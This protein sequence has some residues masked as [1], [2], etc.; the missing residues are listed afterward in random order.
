[1]QQR[2]AQ[3]DVAVVG[4]GPVGAAAAVAF[5]RRGARVLLAEANPRAASRFAGEWIHPPGVDVLRRLDLVPVEG[6]SAHASGRGFVVLPDDGGEP[7]LLPYADG[8]AGLSCEHA[9]LVQ[10]LR[11]RAAALPGV[12]YRPY[13]RVTEVDPG[14]LTIAPRGGAPETVRAGLVVGADGRSSIVRQR[15][16]APPEA[17]LMSHMAGL[18]LHGARLPFEGHGHVLLGGPGP[19]LLYRIGPDTLRICL[20]LPVGTPGARRDAAYLWEAFG[21]VLPGDVRAAFR[22]ALT[23]GKPQW[24]TIRFRARNWYGRDDVTVIGDAVGFYHPLTAAGITLGLLDAECLAQ[25]GSV[26]AYAAQREQRSY[27]PELLS[28]ALYEVLTREDRSA[29][30]I[31]S[32]V[33]D[34]WRTSARERACTMRILST[35]DTDRATFGA[36]FVRMA[37]EAV[38]RTRAEA[39]GDGLRALASDLGSFGEWVQWPAASLLPRRLR[40]RCRSASTAYGPMHAIGVVPARQVVQDDLER[41][42]RTPDE[43]RRAR[44]VEAAH[45][46]LARPIDWSAVRRA[47]DRADALGTHARLRLALRDVGGATGRAVLEPRALTAME[48]LVG[49]AATPALAAVARAAIAGPDRADAAALR[50]LV[51][52]LVSRQDADGGFDGGCPVATSE[53]AIALAEVGAAYPGLDT[54]SRVAALAGAARFLRRRLDGRGRLDDDDRSLS[55]TALAIAALR[56]CSERPHDPALR[57]ACRFLVT[58]Q[59]PDGR[60]EEAGAPAELTTATVVRALL[61]SRAPHW[62]AVERGIAYL[63]DCAPEDP[64]LLAVAAPAL[65]EYARRRDDRIGA[66]VRPSRA[67]EEDFAFCARSLV[68]VSR[69]FARP[70]EMLPGQ[71]RIGVTCGYLLCRTADT[72]ED[73]AHFTVEERDARYAA[74]LDVL[75]RGAPEATFEGMWDGV[76]ASPAEL[77]LCRSL[78]RVMRVFR[79]LP[80]AMQEKTTR[81]VVEMTRGMQLYSHRRPGADGLLALHTVED[82]ERYCYFVAGTVGHMLTDLFLEELDADSVAA[83]LALREHAE[84]FGLGLQLTNILKDVT[85]D[86]ARGVSFIPRTVCAA[87]GIEVA[88]LLDPSLRSRAHGAVAPIF[89]VARDRLDRAFQYTLALPAGAREVRLFCLLPLFMAART[90]V[91]ARGNDA[92]FVPDAPVKISRREVESLIGQCVAS[93]GDD[94]QLRERYAALWAAP[95]EER[96]TSLTAR[97]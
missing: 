21:A 14:R 94:D 68:E 89:D 83:E 40:E 91:H 17:A 20:D 23:C 37:A 2:S 86:R 46:I 26:A 82:L 63:L 93:C 7:I 59:H 79:T 53:A 5:A 77:E 61:D 9:E 76:E 47:A 97:A 39:R 43:A 12:D 64:E 81:W 67:T 66:E 8:A 16:G 58:R 72:I 75:E 38:R 29:A 13:T 55:A 92:M 73:D 49:E 70:I 4:G 69:T 44:L 3:Y 90:L 10:S 96:T 6:S 65:C 30:A 33:F 28:N 78:S 84:A 88:D 22:R 57:H 34:K 60:W 62:D 25:T 1:M 74:F 71:L 87:Q 19:I 85:D 52:G 50:G 32:A 95:R 48:A 15:L 54:P 36:A 80:A 31:R 24:A 41:P 42:G 56:A 27:V 51:L 45:P 11:D 35:A 18:E